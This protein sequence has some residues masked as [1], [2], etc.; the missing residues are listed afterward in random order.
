MLSKS[1]AIF[2]VLFLTI[3]SSALTI[4]QFEV[5]AATPPSGTSKD[6]RGYF[7]VIEFPF[8]HHREPVALIPMT[9]AVADATQALPE[10]RS[11]CEGKR[12][13]AQVFELQNCTPKK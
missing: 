10:G 2:A 13:K 1:F 6:H 8:E 4:E 7:V 9:E 5:V 11:I 12:F 3:G